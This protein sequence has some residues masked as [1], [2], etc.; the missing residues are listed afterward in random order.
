MNAYDVYHITRSPHYPQCNWLAEKNVQ[1]VKSLFYKTKK[2]VKIYSNA[3]WSTAIHLLVAACNHQCK[4]CRAEVQDLTSSCLMQI[5]SSLVYSLGSLEILISRNICLH[6]TYKL[7]KMLCIKMQ[8]VDG[9]IQPPLPVY[10][11]RQEVT[12]LLQGRCHLQEDTSSLKALP[13][14]KQEVRR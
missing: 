2:R 14:T 8:Q 10:V 7:G 4:S 6:M 3:W 9:G 5:D 1:I 13:T 12:S 11:C